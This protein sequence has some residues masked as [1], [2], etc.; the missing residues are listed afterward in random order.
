MKVVILT[1][2]FYPEVG[3]AQNRLMAL[4]RAFK[5]RDHD[6]TVLT[7]LPNYPTGEIFREYSHC[8][9]AREEIDGIPILRSWLYVH[10]SRATIPT[11]LS[12]LT[13]AA[14]CLDIGRREIKKADLVLWEFPPIFLGYTAM[15]LAHIWKAKIVTNIADVWTRMIGEHKIFVP[16]AILRQFEKY[17]SKLYRKS[18]MITG[19]TEGI[20]REIKKN[21]PWSE[22]ILWPN[23]ADPDHFCPRKPSQELTERYNPENRFVI[24]YA[25]LHGRNHNLRLILDTADVLRDENSLLFLFFGDG[26]EKESL[27]A[28]AKKL[29]LTNVQFH[30]PVP[31]P[32]LPEILSLFD[33]GIVIHRNLPGLKSARSAKLFELMAMG[34]PILHCAESEGAEIIRRA[35][36]GE[37]VADD[38][39][40]KVAET[41]LRM[42]DSGYLSKSGKNGRS[43]VKDNFDRKRI[44]AE[45]VRKIEEAVRA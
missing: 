34:I 42:K 5:S 6:I 4:A 8:Y 20:L 38:D 7:S 15:K 24:G 17:E 26:F 18:L 22:P 19:Q 3:A 33:T 12:Y 39:P 16:K 41:I 37:I 2:Y 21:A 14:T 1:Q 43:F 35:G 10:K 44:S 28:Y 23:G 45:I 36:A 32:D 25:G 27:K 29:K 30:D 40:R 11:V 9:K 31:Y 13:F